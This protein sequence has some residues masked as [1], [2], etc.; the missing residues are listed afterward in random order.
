MKLEQFREIADENLS[1][2]T[3]DE[4]MLQ[5]LHRKM[6]SVSA[7]RKPL[8]PR[9]AIAFAAACVAVMLVSGGVLMGTGGV[10]TALMGNTSKDSNAALAIQPANSASKLASHLATSKAADGTVLSY[11]IESV[12]EYS[13][14]VAVAQA[15]NGLYGYVN[16]DKLWVVKAI[17]D[18]AEIVKDGKALVVLQGEEQIIEIPAH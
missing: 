2:L 18:R 13:E 6:C 17:Y 4:R 15:T 10:T 12:E 14:G 1:D 7:P 9:Q 8:V 5:D 3:V 11:G 16:E